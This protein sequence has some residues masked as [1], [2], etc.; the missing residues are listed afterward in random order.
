ML[1]CQC[2]VHDAGY[3]QGMGITAC[4][5]LLVWLLNVYIYI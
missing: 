4:L 2:Y 1:Y 3:V 5:R